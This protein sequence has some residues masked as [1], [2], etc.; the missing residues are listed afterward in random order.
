MFK[1]EIGLKT[2]MMLPV[3]VYAKYSNSILSTTRMS[4]LLKKSPSIRA[5]LRIVTGDCF[6]KSFSN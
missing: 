2:G 4:P 5:V 6:A 3:N 1:K